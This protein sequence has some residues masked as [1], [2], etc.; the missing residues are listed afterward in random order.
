MQQSKLFP[1]FVSPI[2]PLTTYRSYT[3]YQPVGVSRVRCF[4]WTF[5]GLIVPLCFTEMLGLAVATAIDTSQLTAATPTN[6]WTIAYLDG[7]VGG[8]LNQALTPTL[9]RFGQFCL[10]VLAL[11]IIANNCPNIYSLTFSLQVLARAT[12]AVPRFLWTFI[13]TL[14]YIAIAIPG[15]SHFANVLEDFMLLI[16]YWLAIYS[17]ISL[18]EHFVFRRGV[19]GY[20]VS[21]YNRPEKLPPGF[22]AVVAFCFGVLGAVMGMSQTW[23]VGPIGRLIGVPPFGGDIGFPLAFG[24]SATAYAI[25]RTVERRMAGR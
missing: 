15:Y 17:G 25:L 11:S 3:V 6:P 12:Q 9:G 22:A 4:L 23:F 21:Q 10:V 1:V 24:F 7:S 5:A 2:H 16:G 19:R 18:T 8:L 14:I 13:G 20:D